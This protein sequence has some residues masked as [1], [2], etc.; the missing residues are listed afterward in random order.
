V[1]LID[2][3]QSDMIKRQ[4]RPIISEQNEYENQ[5]YGWLYD[6][7]Y[8]IENEKCD[9]AICKWCGTFALPSLNS[10]RLCMQN[11]EILRILSK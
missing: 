5:F 9:G 7:H 4:P 1:A 11:P 10:S 2:K 3:L 8:W 6:S